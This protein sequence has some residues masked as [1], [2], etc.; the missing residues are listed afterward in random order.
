L[1]TDPYKLGWMYSIKPSDWKAETNSYYLAEDATN[2][3]KQEVE[4]FKDFLSVSLTKYVTQPS[5]IILQDGGEIADQALAGLP[6]EIW[7]EFQD[8]FLN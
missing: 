5:A 2:W 7:D 3:A 4:R 8:K 6:E 1:K